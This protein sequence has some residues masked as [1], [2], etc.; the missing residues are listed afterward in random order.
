MRQPPSRVG[1][2]VRIVCA[3]RKSSSLTSAEC[4]GSSEIT[5]SCTG[6]QRRTTWRNNTS[7]RMTPQL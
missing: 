3:A 6:F 4:E 7:S 2:A 1:L 5:H